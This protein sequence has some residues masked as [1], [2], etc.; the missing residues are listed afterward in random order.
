MEKCSLISLRIP[1]EELM[2]P[3]PPKNPKGKRRWLRYSLRTFV[4]V[5]TVFGVWLGLLVHRVNMQ[6]EAV[7]WVKD[8]GGGIAYDFEWDEVK[9]SL[10]DDAK[11]PGPDWLRKLIGIDYFADVVIVVCNNT[12]VVDI[13]SLRELPQLQW[14]GL[15]STQVSDLSP[16]S[17]LTQLQWLSL[18]NTQ[19]SD[20]SPMQ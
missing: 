9:K 14:L 12:K 13:G 10:I 3:Q 11:P 1:L 4:V 7:Q 19:V 16:L 8:H 20:L 15:S 6:K 2:P 5:L 18:S 17:R